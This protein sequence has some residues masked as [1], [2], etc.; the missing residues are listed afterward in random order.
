MIKVNRDPFKKL[1]YKLS[2]Y[3]EQSAHAI[4]IHKVNQ[5]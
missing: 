5:F 1:I 3:D 2:L 4:S